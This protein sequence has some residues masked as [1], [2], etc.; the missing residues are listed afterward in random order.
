MLEVIEKTNKAIK[1]SLGA[2]EKEMV[3][4]DIVVTSPE[5]QGQGYGTTLAKVVTSVVSG[6]RYGFVSLS[7]SLSEHIR[8]SG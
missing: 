5:T 4:L 3:L 6:R 7:L 2:R 8:L 1:E